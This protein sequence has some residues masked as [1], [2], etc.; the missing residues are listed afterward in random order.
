MKVISNQIYSTSQIIELYK[1]CGR[2]DLKQ[3]I[4]FDTGN[5]GEIY[6]NLQL[7]LEELFGNKKHYLDIILKYFLIPEDLLLRF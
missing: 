2:F 4:A 3:E 6:K 7:Y 5:L 1:I